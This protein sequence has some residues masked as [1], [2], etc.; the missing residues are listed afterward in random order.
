MEISMEIFLT[1][2]SVVFSLLIVFLLVVIG[3]HS[4]QGA[5]AL[6]TTSQHNYVINGEIKKRGFGSTS[7]L[8]CVLNERRLRAGTV[9]C[10]RV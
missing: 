4:C 6:I 10:D 7:F 2:F 5:G 1:A 8:F 3:K 9:K